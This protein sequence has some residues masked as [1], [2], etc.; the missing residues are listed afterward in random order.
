MDADMTEEDNS[1]SLMLRSNRLTEYEQVLKDNGFED[2]DTVAYITESDMAELGFK[3][4]DRRKLMNAI[5][6][7]SRPT[8]SSSEAG[9]NNLYSSVPKRKYRRH[10]RP[11]PNA[12]VRPKTAYVRFG[13]S[14]RNDP[15]LRNMSFPDVAKETGR[16]WQA[17]SHAERSEVW[18]EPAREDLLNFKAELSVY[19]DTQ[20]Y[21]QYQEYLAGFREQQ[22]KS[23]S[24]TIAGKTPKSSQFQSPSQVSISPENNQ[25]DENDFESESSDSMGHDFEPPMDH[26]LPPLQAGMEEVARTYSDLGVASRLSKAKPYPAEHYTTAAVEAFLNNTGSLLS[27]WGPDEAVSLIKS[28]YTSDC[29]RPSEKAVQVF[30]MAA[31]GSYCDGGPT[32]S[33]HQQAFLDVFVYLLKSQHDVGA[34]DSMRLMACLAICRFMKSVI[35]ARRLMRMSCHH[36]RDDIMKRLIFNSLRAQNWKGYFLIPNRGYRS[37]GRHRC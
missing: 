3:L 6:K 33:D 29:G 20:E 7:A 1:L 13:D 37:R 11:D 12:L 30:A 14:V 15:S 18:E 5:A 21:K 4:G 26:T 31:I 24:S 35:S 36:F 19:K 34:I 23:E 10:P 28:V 9:R 27:L 32:P 16:R 17:L 2:V 22:S 25:D 8:A